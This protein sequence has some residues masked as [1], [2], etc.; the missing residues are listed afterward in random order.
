[1][2]QRHIPEIFRNMTFLHLWRHSMI[3]S[4]YGGGKMGIIFCFGSIKMAL[5]GNW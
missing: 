3:H 2:R 4:S 5:I 1:M